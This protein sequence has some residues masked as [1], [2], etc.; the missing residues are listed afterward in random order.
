MK[1]PVRSR[2]RTPS[3]I[4]A[5]AE[6]P[7]LTTR[8]MQP[9]VGHPAA[10]HVARAEH[11]VGALGRGDQARQV[12]R[13]VREVGV[14]L[15]HQLRAA[16]ERALEAR[17]VGAARGPP[18]PG[19]CSTSTC[20]VLVGQPV[21][22]LAGAV[23]R[24]VVHDQDRGGPGRW[25]RAGP[26]PRR[27]SPRCSRPRCR[28]AGRARLPA[29]PRRLARGPPHHAKRRDS[30]RLR[31]AGQ[32][33]RARRRGGLPRG[34]LPQRREGDPRGG[35]VG[36]G[37]GAGPG[38]SRSWPGWARRSR[39]RSTPC[40]RA[41][42]SRRRTSCEPGSPPGSWRSRASPASARSA[43][44][45]LH[46]H[47]GVTSLE[48][49]REAAE[50][51]RL[52]DVPGFGKKAAGERGGRA[53]RR[54]R[55]RAALAL[56]AV[57]GARGRRGDRG[58][59]RAA[60]DQGRVG[61][62]RAPDG[63]LVQGPRRGGRHRRPA[64]ARGRVRRARRDRR[65][66]LVRRGRRPCRH[67]RGHP[68][69]PARGARGG[70]REPAPALHRVGQA[71]RGAA[72]RGG[73]AR[74]ARERVRHRRRRERRDR[75]VRHR[76][77]GLRAARDAVHRAGAAREPR[78]AGGG[79]RGRPAGAGRARRHP[80]RPP[81]AHGRLGRPQHDPGDGGGGEGARLQVRRDHRP[82]GQPRLRRPRGP[83]R[84]AAA[85]SSGCGRWSSRASPCS[86]A[87][88]STCCPTARST[89]PTSCSSSSTGWWRASTPRSG[90]ASAR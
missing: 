47:L 89:T 58:R 52:D 46:E 34:G 11:E 66:A 76:G 32:P 15:E 25:S 42:R 16:G 33:L 27:R 50:D 18:L 21:G 54:R 1:P 5:Y 41:G 83:R 2:T 75:G 36:R 90:W 62:Q 22:D 29:R 44:A 4:R 81:H 80:R 55:R 74:A 45:L 9:P 59:P 3:T 14:H 78:R 53:R 31:R 61:R 49:L 6:P 86:P 79:P 51:G 13:V 26:A 40:S 67:P 56:P 72:D 19:R 17:Q 71:Q 20:G 30:R 38:A 60:R 35:R 68:D 70:V 43:C 7:R 64:G 24:A 57:P 8:R 48:D 10:G 84:A 87:P 12:G 37:P 77:G 63:G 69:R 39:R 88:R 28:S 73:P 65:G 82:L 85:R 23:R